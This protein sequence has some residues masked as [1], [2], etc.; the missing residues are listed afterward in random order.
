MIVRFLSAKDAACV[1][2][3]SKRFQKLFTIVQESLELD[4]NQENMRGF[5][6]KVSALPEII[7]RIR[8]F[9]LKY[10]EFVDSADF[11]RV[12]KCIRHVLK[13]GVMD[14]QMCFDGVEK[15]YSL[16]PELFTSKTLAKLTLGKGFEIEAL[17][18]DAFLP[19]LQTLVL[20]SVRFYSLR[21]CA[22]QGLLSASPKLRE[23]VISHMCWEHWEWSGT[24][25]SESLRRLCISRDFSVEFNGPHHQSICF[26]T[27]NLEY[28]NYCDFAAHDYPAV[29]L[30]SLRE[31][32]ISLQMVLNPQWD[33][34]DLPHDVDRY[35]S[36]PDG[37]HHQSICFDTPNLEYLN[38]C[39]FAAHDY[40]AVN[41]Q[42]LREAKISLQMVLNPQWDDVDL[43]HDVDR[44]SSNP[45]KLIKGIRNV[46]VLELSS[47]S[48]FEGLN[49]FC[50][51]IP[52]LADLH[53]LT[54]THEDIEYCWEFLPSLLERTPNLKTLIIKGGLHCGEEDVCRCL[55]GYSCLLTSALEVVEVSLHDS[56]SR[57]EW[58]QLEHFIEKLPCLQL[59]KVRCGGKISRKEKLGME[60][61]LC[62]LTKA[63]SKCKIVCT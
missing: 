8:R 55:S 53:H 13:L 61:E 16:P 7:T 37:P 27:P 10:K 11:A 28:L 43:P 22:F 60:R 56:T 48:T 26:D 45:K 23:L 9:S 40:P 24:F 1:S 52:M 57:A 36:N 34:V 3:V 29:N 14:F 47:S 44:Y 58:D 42:S 20:D 49:Y 18:R 15:G 25:C 2:V 4:E 35:S 50:K 17:P 19:S 31:A 38:Y 51:S 5:L 32:K 46:K 12:N 41:L 21:G 63:S 54:I 39:D 33:D 62:Q 59:L 6:D 30:Q